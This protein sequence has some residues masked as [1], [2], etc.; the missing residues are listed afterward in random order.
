M[1][2]KNRK[3]GS[4]VRRYIR[5]VFD[6]WEKADAPLIPSLNFKSVSI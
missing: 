5:K 1:Q 4:D 3:E 2:Q 6:E